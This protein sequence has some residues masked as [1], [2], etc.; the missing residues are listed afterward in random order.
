MLNSF[1]NYGNSYLLNGTSVSNNQ[2][3]HRSDHT[4]GNG[5]TIIES[6]TQI[7]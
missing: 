2:I 5:K 6:G 3:K 7:P 4:S 1:G